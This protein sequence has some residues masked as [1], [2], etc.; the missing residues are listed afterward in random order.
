M[1]FSWSIAT[2]NNLTP[3]AASSGCLGP[4]CCLGVPDALEGLNTWIGL[5]SVELIL[6]LTFDCDSNRFDVWDVAS[7][8]IF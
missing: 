4:P 3:S 8:D 6:T 1:R 5:E 2:Y 7:E